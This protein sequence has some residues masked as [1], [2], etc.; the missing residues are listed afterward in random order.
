MGDGRRLASRFVALVLVCSS[1]PLL[2]QPQ[3]A[4]A[5]PPPPAEDPTIVVEDPD[6]VPPPPAAGTVVCPG[7]TADATRQ[8]D[9]AGSR[10]AMIRASACH[11]P[12]S[13][14]RSSTR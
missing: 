2:A 4:P 11:R 9:G 12:S 7:R 5:P 6:A 14:R 10:G 13:K 3:S 8:A 1:A